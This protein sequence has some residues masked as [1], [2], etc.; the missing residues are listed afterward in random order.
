MA[1]EPQDPQA[2]RT[3]TDQHVETL[4]VRRAPKYGVFLVLGAAVGVLVAMI[5][6]FVFHG[7]DE[8][9]AAGVQYTQMQVFGFLALVCAVVGLAIGGIIALL[10]DRA[11]ARRARDVSVEVAHVRRD[12]D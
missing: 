6:T 11:M 5:L 4:R 8:P 12:E 3:V 2:P 1:P 7:T 10:F 9:S